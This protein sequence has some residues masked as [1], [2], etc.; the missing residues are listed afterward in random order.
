MNKKIPVRFWCILVILAI[1]LT[2][3]RTSLQEQIIGQWELESETLGITLVFSFKEEGIL[4]VWIEDIPL[5]GSYTWLDEDTIQITLTNEDLSEDI[6]GKVQIEDDRLMIY[7]E[8]GETDVLTRV[9]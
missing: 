1:A 8:T 3:C 6:I 5:D 4:T 9:K 2:A 7:S